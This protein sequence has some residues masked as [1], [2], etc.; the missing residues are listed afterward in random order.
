MFSLLYPA[1]FFTV[2]YYIVC[3]VLYCWIAMRNKYILRYAPFVFSVLVI[4]AWNKRYV[5]DDDDDDD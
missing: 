1:V 2:F 4:W 3:I 5:Y